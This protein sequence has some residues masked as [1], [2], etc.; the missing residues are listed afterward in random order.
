MKAAKG[1]CVEVLDRDEAGALFREADD[2][3]GVRAEQRRA[4]AAQIE[5]GQ[6]PGAVQPVHLAEHCCDVRLGEHDATWE[7]LAGGNPELPEIKR[8]H[9]LSY[10]II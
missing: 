1:P 3:G 5:I 6:V 8:Q 2:R 7:K 10:V 9:M 4:P